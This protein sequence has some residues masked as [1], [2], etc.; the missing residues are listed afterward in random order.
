MLGGLLFMRA[1]SGSSARQ[2]TA[3]DNGEELWVIEDGVA[4]RISKLKMEVVGSVAYRPS[5]KGGLSADLVPL[6][7][8]TREKAL[9]ASCLSNM[10]QLCLAASM[11]AQDWDGAMP[12]E[13]WANQLEPYCKT[14]AIY[15]CP[16]APDTEL[17]FA[18]NQALAGAK[19][20]DVLRPSETV[21]FFETGLGEDV[22]FGGPDGVLME[23]RHGGMVTVGFVDGHAK[24]MKPAEAQKLLEADPFR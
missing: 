1:L 23:P 4:Y 12:A 10:K 18:L 21:L 7:Q 15:A 9:A 3:I 5:R 24:L 11:Y 20:G 2:A 14:R 8:Q 17:G 16:G 19:A 22:P 6:L 13:D